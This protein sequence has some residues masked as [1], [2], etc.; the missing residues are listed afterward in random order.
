MRA[1]M[2]VVVIAWQSSPSDEGPSDVRVRVFFADLTGDGT[3][4]FAKR[5]R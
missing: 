1:T 3:G 5:L 4:I 2:D